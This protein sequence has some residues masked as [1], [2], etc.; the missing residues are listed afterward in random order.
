V[1]GTPPSSLSVF[2]EPLALAEPC[3]V[4]C[5]ALP[6]P[7]LHHEARCGAAEESCVPWSAISVES[8]LQGIQYLAL[9]SGLRVR[10]IEA[11]PST[12]NT[13]SNFS[14]IRKGGWRKRTFDCACRK[15]AGTVCTALACRL[16]LRL[17][18]QWI[19]IHAGLFRFHS[20][21]YCSWNKIS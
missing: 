1:R 10:G 16:I 18:H 14:G 2:S 13:G 8:M 3:P 15:P 19:S 11:N 12:S 21:H 9:I 5:A 4:C 17:L 6:W 7:S 20:S